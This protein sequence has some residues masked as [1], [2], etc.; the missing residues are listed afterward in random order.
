MPGTTSS[1]PSRR[2]ASALRHV[3]AQEE[4]EFTQQLA[5]EARVNSQTLGDGQHDLSVGDGRADLVGYVQRG[6]QRAILV[7]RGTSAALLA[8]EGDEHLML[9]VGS[10]NSSNPFLQIAALEKGRHRLFD[11]RP[12][13]AI[14]GLIALVV[15]LLKGVKMLIEQAPQ[16]GGLRIAWVVE[17]RGPTQAVINLRA[18]SNESTL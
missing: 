14:L 2:C 11:D 10:A 7:A 3:L 8:G 16:V 12:P 4:R 17:R 6:Q 13:V 5:I 15:D 9:S 18:A 1:R